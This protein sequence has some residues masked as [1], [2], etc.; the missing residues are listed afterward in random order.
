MVFLTSLLFT[1]T[2]WTVR[3]IVVPLDQ[4]RRRWWPLRRRTASGVRPM[5]SG[6]RGGQLDRAAAGRAVHQGGDVVA[7]GGGAAIVLVG[8][9][10]GQKLG[11][12]EHGGAVGE[13]ELRNR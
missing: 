7:H 1:W 13:A 6:Q 8:S 3:A 10:H 4:P 11:K 5:G 9:I 2:C 12:I